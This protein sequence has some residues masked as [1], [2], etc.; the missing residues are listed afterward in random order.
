MS[1]SEIKFHPKLSPRQLEILKLSANGLTNLEIA[2]EL[3]ISRYTVHKHF[4]NSREKAN[5]KVS[6]TRIITF[7]VETEAISVDNV[8]G[9]LNFTERKE[10]VASLVRA[11][12]MNKEIGQ[13]LG[14]SRFTVGNYVGEMMKQ[15]NARSRTHLAALTSA[16][17]MTQSS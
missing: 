13:V 6:T 8:P 10:V 14:L 7:L 2:Q 11:G 15:V 16:Y 1:E 3:S 17:R 12:Y 9:Q 4:D 5:K